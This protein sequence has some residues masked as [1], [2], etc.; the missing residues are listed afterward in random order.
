MDFVFE[1]IIALCEICKEI[2]EVVES[3]RDW[4]LAKIKSKP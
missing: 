3:L 4:I 2:S 1:V